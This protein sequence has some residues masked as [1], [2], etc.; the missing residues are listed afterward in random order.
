MRN[1]FHHRPADPARVPLR[2]G[3]GSDGHARPEGGDGQSPMIRDLAAEL[4]ALLA[5]DQAT[6]TPPPSLEAADVADAPG[7]GAA[8]ASSNSQGHRYLYE[9]P[10]LPQVSADA[11]SETARADAAVSRAEGEAYRPLRGAETQGR[12]AEMLA[13]RQAERLRRDQIEEAPAP[14]VPE[15]EYAPVPENWGQA[16][17]EAGAMPGFHEDDGWRV[18]DSSAETP[19]AA[20]YALDR[21]QSRRP[22]LRRVVFSAAGVFVLLAASAVAAQYVIGTGE[23]SG[24]VD[25]D[26][27][28][29]ADASDAALTATPDDEDV[30]T[31]DEGAS[32]DPQ[33]V[34]MAGA[35]ATWDEPSETRAI[36]NATSGTSGSTIGTAQAAE[37]GSGIRNVTPGTSDQSE[38]GDPA[39]PSAEEALRPDEGAGEAAVEAQPESSAE[40]AFGEA[41]E[42]ADSGEAG[43]ASQ[44]DEPF[45]QTGPNAGDATAGTEPAESDAAPTALNSAV[46]PAALARVTTYVNMR[47]APDNDGEVITVIPAEADVD[48]VG[49]EIWCEVV[50]DGQQ[51]WVYE[52]FV[53]TGESVST[54]DS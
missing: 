54:T 35:G 44:P 14:A 34:E 20:P 51:G 39:I 24:P 22:G 37:S 38:E 30:T 15:P 23:R 4:E 8:P 25:P 43:T 41:R 52:D 11:A 53:E 21:Q 36:G 26:A 32:L 33:R 28:A 50:Y 40:S 2:S 19:A 13:A 47:D 10:P 18:L 16:D 31:A 46:G 42:S 48:L 3:G 29:T 17:T 6:R 7:D 12:I 45:G 9:V 1:P 49:C 5:A 27:P